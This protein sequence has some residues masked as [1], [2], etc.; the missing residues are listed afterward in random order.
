MTLT[1]GRTAAAQYRPDKARNPRRIEH[2]PKTA[3]PTSAFYSFRELNPGKHNFELLDALKTEKNDLPNFG[4]FGIL[5]GL[6]LKT[7]FEFDLK[8]SNDHGQAMPGINFRQQRRPS[9]HSH[10]ATN[11]SPHDPALRKRQLPK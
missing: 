8:S 7:K 11:L 9:I 5:L 3:A 6:S 4:V 2:F 10:L 1:S